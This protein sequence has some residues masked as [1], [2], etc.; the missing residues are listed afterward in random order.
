SGASAAVTEAPEITSSPANPQITSTNSEFKFTV[1]AGETST[2]SPLRFYCRTYPTDTPPT[3]GAGWGNCGL[4]TDAQPL[5][6]AYPGLANGSLTFEVAA[7][8]TTAIATQG[9]IASYVWD[10]NIPVP[11]Q[12]PVLTDQPDD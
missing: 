12:A 3:T 7:R 8:E 1:G 5:T 4:S 10:Q 2:V 6:R 9:P 11:T